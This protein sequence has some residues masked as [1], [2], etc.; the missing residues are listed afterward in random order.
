MPHSAELIASDNTA[1]TGVFTEPLISEIRALGVGEILYQEA[2]PRAWVYRVDEGAIAVFER[3]IGRPANI[4][5][6][7]GKG[8]FIGLGC[9][10]HHRDN[11]RAAV[12]SIVS[13]V[14]KAQFDVLA[15]CSPELRHK[16]DDAVKRDFEYGRELAND[17]G[18]SAPVERVAAFL[19]AVSR[20]NSNEG[21]DPAIISDSLKSGVVIGLLNLDFNALERS[22][23][24]LQRMGVIETST[25]GSLYLKDIKAIERIADGALQGMEAAFDGM[26]TGAAIGPRPRGWSTPSS[27]RPPAA[28]SEAI[29]PN[30]WIGGLREATWLAFVIG[31]L[32]AI[33]LGLA[34]MFFFINS[35]KR[36]EIETPPLGRQVTYV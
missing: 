33:S 36:P 7:A 32:S 8:D 23:I 21:R 25:A 17:R 30:S 22:L 12:K 24:K 13:L 16:Q 19:I 26:P 15:Q 18:R 34:V 2:D 20:H 6:M 5:E 11:A 14:H 3:R 35:E 28:R 1:D 9:L 27:L 10:K 29:S 31:G 4:V